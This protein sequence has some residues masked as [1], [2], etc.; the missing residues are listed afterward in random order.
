[1][2][3][4]YLILRMAYMIDFTN[5]SSSSATIISIAIILLSGFLATR[6]TRLFNLPNVTAYI[7]TGI[8]L[9]P[10]V[11]NL[12]SDS[13]VKGTAFLPDLALS[14]IAF[15]TGEFFKIETLKKSGV[16]TLI[17]TVM[18][19]LFAFVLVFIVSF[20]ILRLDLSFSLVLSAL[21]T[22]TAPAST[23]MTIRQTNAKGDFVETLLQVV[24]LDDVVALLAYSAAIAFCQAS[25]DPADFNI[26]G[27][28]KPI[29]YNI[30]A[31]IGGAIFAII[32]KTFIDEKRSTDN[33][34]IVAIAILFGYCGICTIF[35]ISPL[36][37]CM[38]MAMVYINMSDDSRL[39]RQLNYFSPPILLMFFVRSGLNFN[40]DALFEKGN[41][42]GSYP[43]LLI[44]V[45]Y[46][47]VRIIGKYSGS[48]IGSKITG[49]SDKVCRYLGLALLPQAGVAI[50]LAALG[51]RVIGGATGEA[52]NT[53]IM[54]SSILY[55]L[56]GPVC[57]KTALQLSG[58][59]SDKLEDIT[60]VEE[61]KP[62]GQPKTSLELLIERI[63]AIQKDLPK[64]EIDEDEKAFEEAI[65][66]AEYYHYRRRR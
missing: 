5:L 51:A 22:A 65:E 24:A 61:N 58:S 54:T 50:G 4:I 10:Y 53:V 12:I 6:V 44:G 39:F 2:I 13:F 56:V 29:I 37:G 41:S 31:I 34:L 33:R 15:S 32:L 18:E 45:L 21:A 26:A 25:N 28:I 63:N 48:Y 62:D 27:V 40:V 23:M 36:L 47:A 30:L 64:F 57:A 43:L 14:F 17:I 66:E 59:F 52:L 9:G 55:E 7:L 19:A 16:K 60:Q 38:V 3:C 11:L 49:K 20:I 35:D 42:I 1:M 46:F 8:I